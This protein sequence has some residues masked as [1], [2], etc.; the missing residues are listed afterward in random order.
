VRE[1]W[2]GAT[3]LRVPEIA[4]EDVDVEIVGEKRVRHVPTGDALYEALIVDAV[5]DL[6]ALEAAHA[7]G[8]PVIARAHDVAAIEAA[9]SRPE[10]SCALVPRGHAD[11]QKLDLRRLKYG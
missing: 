2:F 7:A 6:D 3:G 5:D 1:R 4:V 10:V 8:L 9:L 11:L